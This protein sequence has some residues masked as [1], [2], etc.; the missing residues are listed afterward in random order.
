MMKRIALASAVVVLGLISFAV[1]GARLD[2]A[3]LP[4]GHVGALNILMTR[5][6]CHQHA[7]TAPRVAS[8]V[9]P[10]GRPK[11]AGVHANMSWPGMN[12]QS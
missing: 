4:N 7:H 11:P 5:H 10:R 3:E 1:S 12:W 6:A 2:C 8:A 9:R